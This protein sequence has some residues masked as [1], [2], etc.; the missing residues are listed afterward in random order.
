MG[1]KRESV[2]SEVT[3]TTTFI[4]NGSNQPH[5]N[6]KQQKTSKQLLPLYQVP[7]TNSQILQRHFRHSQPNLTQ[8]SCFV[9]NRYVGDISDQHHQQQQPQ[10]LAAT[11]E[12]AAENSL[13]IYRPVSRNSNR[14]SSPFDPPNYPLIPPVLSPSSPQ[15]DNEDTHNLIEMPKNRPMLQVSRQKSSPTP[16]SPKDP[17]VYTSSSGNLSSGVRDTL[18]TTVQISSAISGACNPSLKV[19]E[20]KVDNLRKKSSDTCADIESVASNLS[21]PLLETNQ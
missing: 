18:C 7:T 6:F 5:S 8:T 11:S 10:Q 3:T 1:R 15:E 9:T 17:A 12:N 4:T 13:P 19:V 20:P 2:C 14:S 16:S 21:A